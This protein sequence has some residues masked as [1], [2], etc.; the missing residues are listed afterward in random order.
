MN[1]EESRKYQDDAFAEMIDG[2]S[3]EG[4]PSSLERP[5]VV[6]GGDLLEAEI[7]H[8]MAPENGREPSFGVAI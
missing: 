8:S 2:C 6:I 4:V 5:V 1:N 7:L 3:S